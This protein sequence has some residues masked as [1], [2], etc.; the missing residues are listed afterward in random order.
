MTEINEAQA[1]RFKHALEVIAGKH[2]TISV[3]PKI[4]AKVA[5]GDLPMGALLVAAERDVEDEGED[6]GDLEE[7]PL[8]GEEWIEREMPSGRQI[9]IRVLVLEVSDSEVQYVVIHSTQQVVRDKDSFL[10]IYKKEWQPKGFL[11]EIITGRG[12]AQHHETCAY[13]VA[14]RALKAH[15]HRIE[16]RP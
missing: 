5:L 12:F 13:G 1:R 9:P 2:G 10:S 4:V 3:D 7:A 15:G 8:A 14:E 16:H 11:K 6:E